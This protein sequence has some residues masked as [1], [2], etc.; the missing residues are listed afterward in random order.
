MMS[1]NDVSIVW[2]IS[3]IVIDT[4]M[5]LLL[6][7][8]LIPRSYIDTIRDYRKLFYIILLLHDFDS[9]FIW[10]YCCHF[11]FLVYNLVLMEVYIIFF[12]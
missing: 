9:E 7:D 12:I 11:I 5:I 10:W 3:S 2:L 1:P 6:Y 4:M 8:K